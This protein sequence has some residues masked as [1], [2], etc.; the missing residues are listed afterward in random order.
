[1]AAAKKKTG[2]GAKKGRKPDELRALG[3]DELTVKLAEER[4]ALLTMRFQHATAQLE[5]TSSLKSARRGIARLETILKEK[6]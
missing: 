4:K 5:Q 3:R 6:E 2:Q 1:M